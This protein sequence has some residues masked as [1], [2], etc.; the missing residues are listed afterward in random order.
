MILK[1][2]K[3]ENAFTTISEENIPNVVDEKVLNRMTKLANNIRSISP[4][5]DD[6]VYF[7]IIFLKAAESATLDDNGNIK[8]IGGEKAWGYF[9]ENWKW[10]GNVPP[11]RN[12]NYDIFPESELRKAASKWIGLPLCKDHESSSV[13][14]VRGI[15]LDTYYDEKFKQVVGLCAL[16]KINYPDLARKVQNGTVRYGSMGTAVENSIC[17]KCQN[18]AT[19]PQQYCTHIINKTAHG[20]INVG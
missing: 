12:N 1:R 7:S 16:D 20:E 2:S 15:I 13:D 19:T 14:G 5:S 9:D 3:N 18:V 11:H 8:K 6:F 17:S 4:K 10:H